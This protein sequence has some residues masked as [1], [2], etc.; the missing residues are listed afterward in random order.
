MRSNKEMI[1]S[2]ATFVRFI[3]LFCQRDDEQIH[4]FLRPYH[5]LCFVFICFI[6]RFYKSAQQIFHEVQTDPNASFT[7]QLLVAL[8]SRSV[9]IY[10]MVSV[11]WAGFVKKM[12]ANLDRPPC[13]TAPN[14]ILTHCLL[15]QM[16]FCL[17]GPRGCHCQPYNIWASRILFGAKKRTQMRVG[18]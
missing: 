11:N 4:I 16:E 1:P 3:W 10:L 2:G 8:L 13:V 7:V 9:I 5:M 15:C 17:A 12:P 6:F 14:F 18:G